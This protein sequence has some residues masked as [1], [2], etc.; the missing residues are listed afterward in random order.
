MPIFNRYDSLHHQ[1]VSLLKALGDIGPV[2]DFPDGAKVFGLA[3]LVLQVVGV[4][5]R[6][7]AHERFEVA[8]DGILIGSGDQA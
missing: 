3:I 6:V 2:D 7:D 8:D 4:F 5:P 1:H